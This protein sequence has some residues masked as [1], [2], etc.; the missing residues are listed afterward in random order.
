MQKEGLSFAPKKQRRRK[1]L[2]SWL[3]QGVA[4]FIPTLALFLAL[5]VFDTGYQGY[6]LIVWMGIEIWWSVFRIYLFQGL[7]IYRIVCWLAGHDWDKVYSL[8]VEKDGSPSP[9]GVKS[10]EVPGVVGCVDCGYAK[11]FGNGKTHA[12]GVVVSEMWFRKLVDYAVFEALLPL[13]P[14]DSAPLGLGW[15]GL[16]EEGS[17][18]VQIDRV[19]WLRQHL[20]EMFFD[21]VYLVLGV[22]FLYALSQGWLSFLR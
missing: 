16:T 17:K 12:F 5:A 9:K 19:V 14:H 20:R 13:M 8:N 21:A 18:G 3:V 15:P 6:G 7:N 22:L 2:A 1:K 4:W 11:R 10:V